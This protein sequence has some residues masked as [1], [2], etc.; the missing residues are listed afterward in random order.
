MSEQAQQIDA[1][2]FRQILGH[3]PTGVSVITAADSGGAPV[4]GMVVGTFTS[5]S[6]DPPLVAFLPDK[7]S[8]S[9]PHI[10]RAG[11]FCVNVLG[12]DQ[13]SLCQKF[14]RRGGDK[15]EGVSWKPSPSGNPILDGIVA[16]V[17]CTIEQVVESGDHYI[18][19][20]RVSDLQLENDISS[21]LT[22]HR[23]KLGQIAEA[24]EKVGPEQSRETKILAAE[25]FGR[26]Y[27]DEYEDAIT[28][29]SAQFSAEYEHSPESKS[30][31]VLKV[32]IDYLADLVERFQRAQSIEDPVERL[33]VMV[34]AT[35]ESN[36]DHRA[37]VV[38]YQSQRNALI[39][40]DTTELVE[41]ERT[42]QELWVSALRQGQ[43]NGQLRPSDTKISY[44]LMR[45]AL[46]L[47]ARWFREEGELSMEQVA[48]EYVD[49]FLY[50]LTVPSGS[51][52]LT[53]E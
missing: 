27:A 13:E 35:L 16:W 22:F 32:L 19:V 41:A 23:G 40:V 20:G 24:L 49:R 3:Y 28:R 5:V 39:Y 46:F 44:F 47:V 12:S 50:G 6:L 26:N 21:P 15:F 45:D 17:D 9:W 10:E 43:A 4:G 48:Q 30:E 52:G 38:L 37:S 42:M 14:S 25:L 1:T 31:L 51:Q 29:L 53:S 36:R 18:V 7:K 2:D 34:K 8:T 11:R 33:S